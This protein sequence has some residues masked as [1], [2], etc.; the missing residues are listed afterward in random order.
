MALENRILP[1]MKIKDWLDPNNIPV[2]NVHV[3]HQCQATKQNEEGDT[4]FSSSGRGTW[5][6]HQFPNHNMMCW[7]PHTLAAAPTS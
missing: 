1:F 6:L 4:Q 5:Q 2:L 3:D 7:T